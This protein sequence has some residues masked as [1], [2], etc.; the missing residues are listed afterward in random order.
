MTK[1]S[2][3]VPVYNTGKYIEK[4]IFSII[5]QI[6]KN[7]EV[8]LIDDGSTD[9]SFMLATKAVKDD[10]RFK[11]ISQIN[12]GL[13]SARNVGIEN[14]TGEFVV[15]LD[16]DDYLGPN[17]LLNFYNQIEL[18]Y[19]FYMA[20]YIIE[21]KKK[22]KILNLPIN[23]K[24]NSKNDLLG[25]FLGPSNFKGDF[26]FLPFCVWRNCYKRDII[27]LN[28]IR[29]LNEREIMLEDYLFNLKFLLN[30][31]TFL[32]LP[33][34]DYYHIENPNSLSKIYRHNLFFMYKNLFNIAENCIDKIHD[35]NLK[36]QLNQRIKN[37]YF[38]SRIDILFNSL[39]KS[40]NEFEVTLSKIS[41]DLFLKGPIPKLQLPIF[42]KVPLKLLS[43][44]SRF[45]LK[46]LLIF[47]QKFYFI[48]IIIKY[49]V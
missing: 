17:F 9:N 15:F 29:F 37:F 21:T 5:N 25:S 39:K 1:F 38:K 20:S 2:I 18:N 16:S 8:I 40:S 45:I 44:N 12:K 10:R 46:Y 3:I 41:Q 35:N 11:I 23:E 6:Y 42:Y 47:Y 49:Y 27:V 30:I 33:K 14:S 26:N 19:D 7:F 28:N 32:Y 48:Y 24:I 22:K 31:N 43:L 13:S 34:N 36:T 4:C